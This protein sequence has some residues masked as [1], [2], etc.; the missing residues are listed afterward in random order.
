M[1][2]WV[3]MRST[4]AA[5]LVVA[6]HLLIVGCQPANRLN[7]S[8]LQLAPPASW[9][10]VK[11][12][13]WIAPG[14]PLAAWSGPSGSSL[15]LYR[16]LPIPGGSPVGVVVALANR[17]EN[18]PGLTVH[19]KRVESI[20]NSRAARVEVVAPGTGDALAP[21]G[22]GTPVVPDGRP[23]VPTRQVTVAFVQSEGTYYLTWHVP[24]AFYNQ[25]EPDI[26]TVLES[27][28]FTSSGGSSYHSD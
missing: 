4:R 21:T 24:A 14:L 11:A 6:F 3:V 1:G 19:V 20:G 16:T 2:R 23:L 13:T 26:K 28:Q 18:L 9:R 27:V 17:L 5:A 10:P 8:G 25:I 12:A 15:V 22:S 7:R